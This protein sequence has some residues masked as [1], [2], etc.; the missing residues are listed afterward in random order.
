MEHRFTY[1]NH[2]NTTFYIQLKM[3][4]LKKI[5]LIAFSILLLT[6][7]EGKSQ[8]KTSSKTA[9]KTEV[10]KSNT[11]QKK[12]ELKGFKQSCCTGIVEYSLKEV[13]GFIK[14]EADVKNQELTVWFDK[15]ICTEEDIKKAINKTPYKI[16]K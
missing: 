9:S 13:P 14:S 15:T 5:T 10:V 8:T 12:Y 7:C 11:T 3:K 16:V 4:H 6:S 2:I 1:N